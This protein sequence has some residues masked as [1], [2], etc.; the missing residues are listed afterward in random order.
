MVFDTITKYGLI[1]A[2][3]DL[4]ESENDYE[5]IKLN[6]RS[7]FIDAAPTCR[8]FEAL[9]ENGWKFVAVIGEK[10]IVERIK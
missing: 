2:I 7:E 6:C 4:H 3:N 9:K 1:E 5:E 10:L 8:I